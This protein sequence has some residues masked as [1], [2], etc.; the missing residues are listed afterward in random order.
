MLLVSIVFDTKSV[1][2]HTHTHSLICKSGGAGTK[3]ER[4]GRP[5]EFIG[6][7]THEKKCHRAEALTEVAHMESIF[8]S[9]GSWKK[10]WP[11]I[12]TFHAILS[13][14]YMTADFGIIFFNTTQM[15]KMAGYLDTNK[16]RI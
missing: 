1:Y 2:T 5:R 10:I 15:I 11:F 12:N 14:F 9:L 6:S 16:L 3:T 13:K 8:S 7:G 4:G